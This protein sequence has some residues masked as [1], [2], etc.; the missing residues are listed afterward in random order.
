MKWLRKKPS[1]TNNPNQKSGASPMHLNLWPKQESDEYPPP[2][3]QEYSYRAIHPD[4]IDLSPEQLREHYFNCGKNE[5]R[6]GNRLRDRNDFS[7]L[8]S[9]NTR[10]L[11]IG[12]FCNPIKTGANVDHAD[13]LDQQQLIERAKLLEIPADRVPP[14]RHVLSITPLAKITDRYGAVIS[15]HS[16]EH[17]PDLIRHL[18]DVAKLLEEQKGR[19]FIL[20]PDK[21]YCFDRYISPSTIAEVCEAYDQKRTVH[22]LRSVIEHRSMTT[23][24]DPIAHW[25]SGDEQPPIDHRL[26]L[27]AISIWKAS[28][29]GYVDVHA[30]YFTPE[31]F[32]VIIKLLKEMALISLSIEAIYPTRR[33]ANEFWAILRHD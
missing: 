20:I 21:R 1:L 26:V 30:W 2:E 31:S 8:I 16:I 18:Q 29:G 22:T 33:H 25:N 24:N 3:Y 28:Q 19:Y 14:I 17:Q 15:S 7:G 9:T 32:S 11:E 12:P 23:H 27:D 10:T 6:Q 13:F 4:L 5:G